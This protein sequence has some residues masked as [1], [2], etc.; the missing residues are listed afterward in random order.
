MEERTHYRACNLCEAICGLEIKV[1]GKEIISINGD[2]N[3]PF[4]RGH[5][6]PKAVGLKDIYEDPNRLKHP[7][8]RTE[9]GWEQISWEEA[10][11]EV[12]ENIKN[13]QV[14][15]GKNAVGIY[16]GN[17]AVHNSGTLLSLP[18]FGKALNTKSRF[19]ATSSDQ[20]PHHIIAGLLYGHP[21]LL[22]IPDIDHTDFMVIM[23]GNPMASNGSI[24]TV[25]D[26][27]NR[28]K[29]IQQRG[30]KVIV[31]DPRFT[32][33]SAKADEHIFIKPGADA[34]LLLAMANLIFSRN[35]VKLGHLSD[36]IEGLDEVAD[37]VKDYTPQNV[38]SITGIDSE[39]IIALTDQFLA[40]EKAVLYGRMGLSV[41]EFGGIC[42]WLLNV[43]NIIAGRLDS[44]GG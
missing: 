19:S 1:K 43:V 28:L 24:M 33:T 15:Y 16:A 22:P 14:K 41:Q 31:I 17:P 10:F 8:R 21:L 34:Y 6:C 3:D 32:E 36:I 39:K 11:T 42:Q 30:G 2:K 18:G 5:I 7:L 25:P 44:E 27:A 13:T 23:G 35:Q 40:A 37:W 9:T 38:A 4:S 26:V 20:L 29:A 12:V